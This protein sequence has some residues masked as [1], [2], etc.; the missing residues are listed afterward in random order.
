MPERERVVAGKPAGQATTRLHRRVRLAAL[1]KARLD[2]AVGDAQR[3]LDVTVGEDAR[4]G[5]IGRNRCVDARKASIPRALGID[6]GRE[7]LVLDPDELAG[8][9]D[10]VAVLADDA[11]DGIA[12]EADLV[13]RQRRHLHRPEPLDRRRDSKRCC[14]AGQ[15][16]AGQHCDDARRLTCLRDVDAANQRMSVRAAHEGGVEQAGR[17]EVADVAAAPEAELARLARAQRRA[18][19]PGRAVGGYR[20]PPGDSSARHVSCPRATH[21]TPTRI[22]SAGGRPTDAALR[23]SP[24]HGARA[25]LRHAGRRSEDRREGRWP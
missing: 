25:R 19:V 6:D 20:G 17:G 7:T 4:V 14:G 11:G 12:D 22:R 10:L 8:V 18:D 21:R 9:C 24:R 2:H 16:L 3:R 5:A 13:G 23:T 1:M 15:V